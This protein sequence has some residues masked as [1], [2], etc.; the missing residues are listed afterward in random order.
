MLLSIVANDTQED[1]DEI[2]QWNIDNLN[3]PP[4]FFEPTYADK[5]R[6]EYPPMEDGDEEYLLSVNEST[7]DES[8]I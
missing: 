4:V 8:I 7:E 3:T 2:V 5:R 1:L 6:A